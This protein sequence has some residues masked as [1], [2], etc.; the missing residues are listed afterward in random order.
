MVAT[1][2]ILLGT[3]YPLLLDAL[4]G[5]KL[6]VGPPYFNLL[7]L[8]LM[9]LL[10]FALAI[11][12]LLRWK[13]TPR[14]WLLRLLGPVFLASAGLGAL[15]AWFLA[16][17]HW[18]VLAVCMLAAWVLLASL[19]DVWEKTRQRGLWA[20]MRR[21]PP[22]YWGMQLAHVG[23]AVCALGIVLSTQQNLERDMR[24]APGDIQELGGYRFLFEGTT[25]RQGPNYLAD[26]ARIQ[27]FNAAG[28]QITV[29]RPEKRLYVVQRMPMTEAGIAPG[30]LCDLYVALGE[31]LEQGAWAVRLHV[32]PFIRW[33]W[34]G[35][36]LMAGGGLLAA[37][38][39]R[40]RRYAKPA[41]APLKSG[42]AIL[43]ATALSDLFRH[44]GFFVPRAVS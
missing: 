41:S 9:G 37:A 13:D 11:G 40:Y 18:L 15:A 43:V 3:L 42:L 39:R 28:A 36:L 33:I 44:G 7:F 2:T 22:S 26:T 8:P 30:L 12:V 35:G 38:D 24:M 27:V 29:L 4:S 14:R 17:G 16:D 5:A 19:C 25:R 32:K 34:L 10:M 21:L 6:S 23:L 20:G 31:P 1:A